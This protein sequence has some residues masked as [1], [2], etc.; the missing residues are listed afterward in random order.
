MARVTVKHATA[1]VFLFARDEDLWHVGLIHHP[2][3]GKWMLPGGHSNPTRTPP[4]QRYAKSPKKP[5]CPLGCSPVQDS[6]S[7]REPTTP[8]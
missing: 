5:A 1:S 7:H 4:R 8:Q 6:I 3:F 2:R